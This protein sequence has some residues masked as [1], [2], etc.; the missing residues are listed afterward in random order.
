MNI[1]IT[2]DG[3]CARIRPCGE[4]DFN[5]LPPLRAA[6]DAL[7]PKVTDVQWDLALTPFMDVAG[8]HLLFT[9][10]TSS[11]PQRRATVTGLRAQPLSLL[12]MAA[13]VNPTAFDLCR[14]LPDVPPADLRPAT[15]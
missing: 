1:T 10:A 15:P 9:P 6:V 2:I 7:P 5:I 11:G 4:I 8:L 3:T 13:D 12:L 14:L